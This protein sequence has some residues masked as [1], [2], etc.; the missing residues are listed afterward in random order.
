VGALGVLA[1]VEDL[2]TV[3]RRVVEVPVVYD[4]QDLAEVAAR[5]RLSPSEV[6]QRHTAPE[7]LV[8]FLGFAHV[9]PYLVGLAS[10]R[11]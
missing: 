9:F 3:R 5:T 10:R 2:E 8:A 11:R 4:G 1:E 7:Y 6:V